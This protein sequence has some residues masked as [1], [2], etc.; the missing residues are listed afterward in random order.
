MF[1]FVTVDKSEM[2]YKDFEAYKAVYCSLC[3][4]LG[5]EYTFL[6]RFIL[7]YDCTFY[8]VLALALEKD[9]PGFCKG[10]CKVNPLKK[11]SFLIHGEEALSKA[12]ALSVISVYYKLLDNIAD[13]GFFEKI[14]CCILKPFFSNWRKKASLKYPEIDNAV[15]TMSDSQFEVEKDVHCGIDKAAEPTATM[16]STV[17]KLLIIN[18]AKNS[19]MQKTVISNFGYF[20]GKWIYLMDAAVDFESD[21]KRG[22]FNPYVISYGDDYNSKVDDINSSL[23][24]CLS[25]AFLSYNLLE[26]NH[27]KSIIEN[28]L[29]H[30]LPK[31][32]KSILYKEEKIAE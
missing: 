12:A 32:Q 14:G 31:K 24:Y 10:R 13:G 23:D 28:L 29:I 18:D 6:S 2:L 5:K 3:K 16:L 19:V 20:L 25:E 27:F 21:I 26:L 30:G 4:Q 17:L 8:A 11:C 7:S 1:G 15:K 9:C 22:N